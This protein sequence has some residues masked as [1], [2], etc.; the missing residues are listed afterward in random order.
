MS[1]L[2]VTLGYFLAGEVDVV[3]CDFSARLAP[4]ESIISATVQTIVLTGTDANP[5][6]LLYGP[7]Q[8]AGPV[9]RQMIT[10]TVPEVTYLLTVFAT[11]SATPARV[12]PAVCVIPVRNP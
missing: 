2:R 9:V 12:L 3:E 6:A 11:T 7:A 4:G 8:A 1:R 5:T 10:P